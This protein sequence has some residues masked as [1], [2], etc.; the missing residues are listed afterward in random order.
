MRASSLDQVVDDEAVSPSDVALLDGHLAPPIT[1]AHF[2]T[3][4]LLKV[5]EL[6]SKSLL[7]TF[8]GECDCNLSWVIRTG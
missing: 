8:I 5:G 6:A 1:R 4:H 3:D 7:S 2:R